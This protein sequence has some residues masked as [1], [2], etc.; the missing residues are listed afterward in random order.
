MELEKRLRYAKMK[1]RH[2]KVFKK[3]YFKPWGLFLLLFI[4]I[5][6]SLAIA[7]S[8]YVVNATKEYRQEIM[9]EEAR[10]R[11]I[12][13]ENAIKGD[14][15]NIS[16]GSSDA[17]FTIVLFSDFACPVCADAMPTIIS[18]KEEYSDYV[19]FVHRDFPTQFNSVEI[20]HSAHCANE[21]NMYW[22]Y[23]QQLFTQQSRFNL[24]SDNDLKI[25]LIRL[26][27][28][29]GMSPELFESCI[30]EKRHI[31]IISNDFNDS[32]RLNLKGTPTW[33]INNYQ[34]TGHI[35]HELFLKLINQLIKDIS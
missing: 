13:Y 23:Y 28:Q 7:S 14:R 4:A 30:D 22:Q 25:E 5:L 29:L 10:K 17:P 26:A 2:K 16:F 3:W 15:N 12:E 33:F 24:L 8:I 27:K 31:H 6:I 18:F 35:E 1:A 9:I 11:F 34:V 21:Q 19:R 32:E 20:A